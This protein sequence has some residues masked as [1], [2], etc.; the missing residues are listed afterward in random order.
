MGPVRREWVRCVSRSDLNTVASLEME[1][2][3]RLIADPSDARILADLGALL[4]RQG[5]VAEA[6][7][8]LQRAVQSRPC[9]P[10][11]FN[12]LGVALQRRGQQVKAE[13][14]YRTAIRQLR[15]YPDAWTNLGNILRIRGCPREAAEA[16]RVAARLRPEDPEP[17]HGL[18]VALGD[19]GLLEEAIDCHRRL[20][21]LRP[22]SASLHSDLVQLLHHDPRETPASLFEEAL[23]WAKRHEVPHRA[24]VV[25]ARHTN[26]RDTARRLRVGYVSPD[27]RD[28]P[29]GRLVYPVIAGHDRSA[30]EVF[31]YADVKHPDDVT[32]QLRARADSWARH[33]GDCRRRSGRAH[34]RRWHRPARRLRRT[35]RRQP[36]AR[37]RAPS[38]A[39]SGQPFRLLRYDRNAGDRLPLD[40]RVLRSAWTDGALPH[41]TA[42]AV[43]RLLLVLLRTRRI[44]GRRP[45]ART[46][47]RARQVRV[48]EPPDQD[49]RRSSGG[50]VASPSPGPVFAASTTIERPGKPAV[51][52]PIR[53]A[54]R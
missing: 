36:L 6:V 35:L 21:S 47:H 5:E 54:W 27:F 31:C 23:R 17:L 25:A 34:S 8:V 26:G 39:G 24:A 18:A 43:A 14:A 29:V 9:F 49:H 1:Y 20:V 46:P 50:L 3:Q 10:E 38:G 33:R 15:R 30:F 37:V 16:Y 11:A 2:R 28:H 52:G 41:G 19:Q 4:L 22:D 13:H 45:A 44:T 48:P 53:P 32:M 7:D 40:R 51:G 42:R 12:N